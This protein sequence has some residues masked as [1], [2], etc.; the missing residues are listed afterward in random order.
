LAGEEKETKGKNFK[1]K[2]ELEE[3]NIPYIVH[4]I[5]QRSMKI[6]QQQMDH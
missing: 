2:V 1:K 5:T 3:Q 6:K 4:V